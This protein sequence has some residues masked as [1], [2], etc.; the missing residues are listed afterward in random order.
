MRKQII[1]TLILLIATAFITVVYFKNLNPPGT[2]TSRIINAIPDN[3]A[4]VFEFN[5]DQSFY[6]IFAG[7]TLFNTILGKQEI[8]ELDTLRRQLLLNPLLSQYF[9][10]QN[11]FVSLH[12]SK[13]GH[14]DLLLTMSATNGF[15]STQIDQLTK[16]SNNGL[17]VTPLRTGGRQSFTIYIAALK[18]RFYITSNS[19]NIFSGSFSK[20]LVDQSSAYKATKT[21]SSFVLLTEQQT[22]NSLANLYVNY[23]QLTPLFNQLFTNKN[24]DIFKSFRLLPAK[25][26]LSLNYKS[27]ALMFSGLTTIQPDKATSY[28]NLFSYQQ[29]IDN[30]LKDIFPSTTAYSSNF[31]VSDPLKFGSDLSKWYV[32]GGLKN[33]KD[34]LF[35]KITAETGSSFQTDF[36]NLLGNEFAI[37]TTRYF[38]KY[39]IVS[40]KDGSK[41]KSLI[42]SVSTMTNENT[43][44]LT[45]NKLPFFLLGDAFSIFRQPYFMIID[46]YLILANSTNELKSFYDSYIN[47]KFLSKNDQYNQFDNLLSAKSNVAFF[48]NFKNSEQIL[49]RDLDPDIY[50][51]FNTH[52]PGFK[53]F[54]AAS[55][56]FTATGKNFYTNFCMKVNTDTTANKH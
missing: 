21:E 46:N 16:Q 37:V 31:A 10:G 48:F 53:D 19:D 52:E 4:L 7:N 3:A 42:A 33:E 41:V 30:H 12:P 44:R 34:Q 13:I 39:A 26:S 40:V 55:W 29:P 25:A 36:N 38:E 5:N 1:I 20:E 35:N 24:T 45:Y 15:E 9:S 23:N 22:D 50:E 18:K 11:I 51:I 47:R 27:E 28:L 6:D 32:K 17:V 43:G 2:R 8:G 14:I 49:K 56:Q 54:Y